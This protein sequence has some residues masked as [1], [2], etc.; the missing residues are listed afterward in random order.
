MRTIATSVGAHN[1]SA[2]AILILALIIGIAIY[3]IRK[4][5]RNPPNGS[6]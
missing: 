3:F 6:A 4:R 2:V 1:L 5:R